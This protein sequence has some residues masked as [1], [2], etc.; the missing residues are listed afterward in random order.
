MTSR[1][2]VAIPAWN[3]AETIAGVAGSAVQ[4]TVGVDQSTRA[5]GELA[6]MSADLRQLVGHFTV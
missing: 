2:L 1:L 6:R 5:V 4:T 3:E